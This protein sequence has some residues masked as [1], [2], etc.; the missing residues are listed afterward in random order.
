M[1]RDRLQFI[2]ITCLVIDLLLRR[3]GIGAAAAVTFLDGLSTQIRL[4][5]EVSW[6]VVQLGYPSAHPHIYGMMLLLSM[7][8]ATDDPP[9]QIH[10]L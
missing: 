4:A 1:F 5:V 2:E 6:Y 7:V 9:P 8:G 3:C 10:P